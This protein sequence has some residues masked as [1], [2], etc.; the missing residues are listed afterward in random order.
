MILEYLSKRGWRVDPT[1]PTAVSKFYD[2]AGGGRDAVIY[3]HNGRLTAEYY[4]EG[5]NAISTCFG[6]SDSEAAIDQFLQEIENKINATYGRRVMR[7]L[8]EAG[9]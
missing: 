2:S 1:W 9:E 7:L 5:N 6:T 4:S 3:I 8:S